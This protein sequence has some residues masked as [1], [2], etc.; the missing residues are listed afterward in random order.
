MY[1]FIAILTSWLIAVGPAYAGSM[2][3][4]GAGKPP[5]GGGGGT[6]TVYNKQSSLTGTD[7]GGGDAN[8]TFRVVIGTGDL[9]APTG[10]P[11][12]FRVTI[13]WGASSPS[14]TG[15]LQAMYCGQGAATGNV[16][17]FQNAPTQVKF[18]GGNTANSS[19]GGVVTSDFVNLPEA[20]SNTSVFVCAW[21][22]NA[23]SAAHLSDTGDTGGSEGWYGKSG[24]DAATQT[25]T[26]YS[27]IAFARTAVFVG[28]IEL[29]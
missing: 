5:G 11:T 19:A 23:G 20:F 7:D 22:I 21:Y 28:K 27:A 10:S 25:A 12:Q 6:Q 18:S 17:S 4:L 14:E 15:A 3:L 9:S 8:S 2:A 24:N 13:V 29:Q 1:Q 26:G 16:Y